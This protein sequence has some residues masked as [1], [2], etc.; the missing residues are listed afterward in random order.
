M[1]A[2]LA[3]AANGMTADYAGAGLPD[4]QQTGLPMEPQYQEWSLDKKVRCFEDS[5]EATDHS[6]AMSERCRDY[7]DGTQLTAEE[8]RQLSLRGQPD[9]II[10]R[11]QGK[12]NYLLGYEAAL[13]TDPI[14]RP[15]TPQDEEA[16]EACTDALNYVRDTSD[17]KQ[18]F[19]Q[20]WENMLIEG[21]GGSE[22]VPVLKQGD[23]DITIKKVHWDRA[24]WD[25]HAREHDFDDGRY[26][27]QVIWMDEEDALS[28][29]PNADEAITKT[30]SDEAKVTYS[31]RP[32][33]RQ[34]ATVGAHRK[35]VRI[36]QMY[37]KCRSLDGKDECWHWCIFTKGGEIE[38]G[39]VP[40]RDD[41]GKS[42]CPLVLQSAFVDRQNNRYGFVKALLGPQD[43]INKR[44]SKLLHEA[45]VRQFTYEDGA[46]DDVDLVKR[47]LA[48]PDGAVKVNPGL[49]FEMIDRSKE[50]AAHGALQQ[51]A[52]QEIE[53]MGPN[54]S[55][56]GEQGGAP[57]GRA[58]L[59]NQQGG[60]IELALLVD[61]H[62]HYKARIHKLVWAMI[63]MYWKEEKWVRVTD[64]EDNVRFVGFNRPMTL[65]EVL[66]KKAEDEGIDPD[67]AKA[68]LREA[69]QDPMLAAQLQEVVKNEHVPSEMGMDIILD[70]IPD[71]ANI[72]A[73]QFQ[74]LGDL[75]KSGVPLPPKLLIKA[76]AL[77]N[78]KELLAELDKAEEAA[79]NDPL[80]QA[81]VQAQMES[82]MAE[83]EKLK[84][85]IAKIAAETQ[86]TLAE[87]K[88][89]EADAVKKLAE[90]D[91]VDQQI[92]TV[93]DP[94]IVS[95]DGSVT[96]ARQ[97]PQAM[98]TPQSPA[99]KQAIQGQAAS[100]QQPM[101][102]MPDGSMMAD[103][104]MPMDEGQGF[105]PQ[106]QMPDL[107][108]VGAPL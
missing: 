35:R 107:D 78:K 83:I 10:N 105:P 52:K 87:V 28:M 34:W 67:E 7:Y 30:I 103:E 108:Q 65:A 15:R 31:D 102:Q 82:A 41:D 55:M 24:F 11:I 17:Q 33:W 77:R 98:P 22:V 94:E 57:S 1:N 6:R 96:P 38:G 71:N 13:R 68:Q 64:D 75:A 47:E 51:E 43:E 4:L 29:W 49:K 54:S 39:M 36:V 100:M 53:L 70:Q 46:I 104:A 42:L 101:H 56:Q 58:I 60:Q 93:I 106:P 50:I 45:T 89:T 62:N 72:Q 91:A 99:V 79:Q 92:G 63:K 2:L 84:A 23:A 37:Y 59:A 8:L 18:A 32:R 27:G 80:Q 86:K 74:V 85:E 21:A 40:Y 69:A 44:R 5:E 97:T 14:G 48:K 76:S 90:A 16:S 73:E 20:C 61:R 19:S 95:S 26:L 81:A 88:S 25:P 66:L 3:P 9:I 12:V